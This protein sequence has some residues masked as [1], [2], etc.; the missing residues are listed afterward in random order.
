MKFFGNQ[1]VLAAVRGFSTR[2]N[3]RGK[4]TIEA[5]DWIQSSMKGWPGMTPDMIEYF[6]TINALFHAGENTPIKSLVAFGGT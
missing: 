4:V 5:R 2:A 1:V 3:W 6:R